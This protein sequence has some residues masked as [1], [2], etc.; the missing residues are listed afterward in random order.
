MQGALEFPRP[1]QE[2]EA[3]PH[4]SPCGLILPPYKEPSCEALMPFLIRPSRRFPVQWMSP[5]TQGHFKDSKV[6]YT[7]IEQ[8]N[9]SKHGEN[10]DGV[11]GAGGGVAGVVREEKTRELRSN[12]LPVW[13]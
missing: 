1:S 6:E 9:A 12:L 5:T 7:V 13:S 8:A 4:V 11:K 3:S 10:R 2:R